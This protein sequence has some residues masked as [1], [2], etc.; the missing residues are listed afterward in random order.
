MNYAKLKQRQAPLFECFFAFNQK[1][2][3]QGLEKTGLDRSDVISPG[4]GLYGSRRGVEALRKF[5]Q[6]THQLMSQCNPQEVYDYEFDNHECDYVGSDFQAMEF[7]LSLFPVEK[8]RKIQRR[9]DMT[10]IEK[11][12]GYCDPN[13]V[14]HLEDGEILLDANILRAMGV[15]I[16]DSIDRFGCSLKSKLWIIDGQQRHELSVSWLTV[17]TV[18]ASIR[19][20]LLNN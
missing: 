8:V 14:L 15:P 16:K 10:P 4:M 17:P 20:F 11:I 9:W 18:L 5:N 13:I 7:V 3:D 19:S 6:E 12:E 2:F 1:Q